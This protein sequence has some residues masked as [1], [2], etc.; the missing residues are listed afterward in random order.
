MKSKSHRKTIRDLSEHYVYETYLLSFS[1]EDKIQVAQLLKNIFAIGL[2]DVMTN[3]ENLPFML[4][5]IKS[6][7]KAKKIVHELSK[8]NIVAEV[9][10]VKVST[11][12]NNEEN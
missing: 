12:T 6:E 11:E 5:Q 1:K 2:S 4:S 10:R 9:K 3:M 7:K 8:H